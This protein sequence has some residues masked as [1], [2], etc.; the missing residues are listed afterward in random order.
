MKYKLV[1][2]NYRSNYIPN[3]MQAR[4]V[5]N[6]EDFLSYDG[7][8]NWSLLDNLKKG[9]ACITN[10]VTTRKKIL[11]IVDCDCD[12]FTSAAIIYQYLSYLRFDT[13]LVTYLIHDGKQHGLE[14]HVE[15]ILDSGEQYGLVI[16]PDAGSND[17]EFCNQLKD[18]CEKFLI[19]D[20]HIVENPA[21]ENMIVINNQSSMNYEN[22][23]LTGTG[24][25]YRFCQALDYELKLNL[26]RNFID[27]AALGICGDMGSMLSAEN[28]WF[29]RE[30]FSHIQNYMFKVLV[31]KQSFSM[32]GE[33]TPMI[34]AFY[35]VPLINA[36]I[37]VGTH[38]EKVRLFEAF[39]NGHK[40]IPCNKRGAKGTMEECAVESARECTN[41]KSKQT[42]IKDAA[43]DR[44]LAK[45]YKED[46]LENKILFVR[47][48]EDDQ[49]PAELNGSTVLAR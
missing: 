22:K 6:F 17:I 27:L 5:E 20:H 34:V 8:Q 9:I 7:N 15:E 21:A 42:K 36:M 4:G 12:G 48:D 37:R 10:V 41:A 43:I 3:L 26:A 13:D 38:E 40:M 49:F 25:V 46:L 35:I 39:I 19:L 18:C 24:V 1:N 23:D 47:L 28:Q 2:E 33:V 44:I 30:G 14:D 31:E 45:I 29:M 32:G 16:V 11:L